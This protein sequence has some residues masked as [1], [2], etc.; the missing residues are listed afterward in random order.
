MSRRRLSSCRTEHICTYSTSIIFMLQ[1]NT[2]QFAFL[3]LLQTFLN[4]MGCVASLFRSLIRIVKGVS[5]AT[6]ARLDSNSFRARF[7]LQGIRELPWRPNTNTKAFSLLCL[8]EHAF[9][10]NELTLSPHSRVG[11]GTGLTGPVRS[12]RPRWHA[13]SRPIPFRDGTLVL[14]ADRP[15]RAADWG[16]IRW[17]V[18]NFCVNIVPSLFVKLEYLVWSTWACLDFSSQAPSF[19]RELLTNFNN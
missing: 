19:R 13:A 5:Q 6:S 14:S 1:L 2:K 3:D 9:S 17:W 10:L 12:S 4:C 15:F 7:G 18:F 11:G 8:G 16:G